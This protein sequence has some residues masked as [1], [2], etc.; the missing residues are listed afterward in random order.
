[1]TYHISLSTLPKAAPRGPVVSSGGC[2]GVFAGQLPVRNSRAPLDPYRA[3]ALFRDQWT[4]WCRA[5]F[6]SAVHLAAAFCVS[7]KTARM[8]WD[9]ATAPQGWAVQYAI[10]AMPEQAKTLLEAA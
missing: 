2:V 7:E 5:N 4:A 6:R 9:G 1:M 8:W 3:R 10:T